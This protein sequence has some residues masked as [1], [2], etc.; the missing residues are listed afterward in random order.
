MDKPFF[1]GNVMI[2]EVTAIMSSLSW[3]TGL[4]C[5]VTIGGTVALLAGR[6]TPRTTHRA[7]IVGSSTSLHLLRGCDDRQAVKQS[8]LE[9][10]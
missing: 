3:T 4:V 5:L 7:Q 6:L 1:I 2:R 9:S 8:I 10:F